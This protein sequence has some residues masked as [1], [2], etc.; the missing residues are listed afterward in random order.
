MIGITQKRKVMIDKTFVKSGFN[1]LK[2]DIVASIGK[3]GSNAICLFHAV[4]H[5]VNAVTFFD[6]LFQMIAYQIEIFMKNR[7][8]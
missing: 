2:R 6:F 5:D 1:G 4:A 3:N 8:W 7:L